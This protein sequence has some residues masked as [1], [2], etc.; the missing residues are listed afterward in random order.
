VVTRGLVLKNFYQKILSILHYRPSKPVCQPDVRGIWLYRVEIPLIDLA[1]LNDIVIWL[2][3]NFDTEDYYIASVYCSL[4][5]AGFI[6][7]GGEFYF[8]TEEDLVR[9]KLTWM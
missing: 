7:G 6:D 8:R 4:S 3:A 1:L 5:D 9:F 2:G